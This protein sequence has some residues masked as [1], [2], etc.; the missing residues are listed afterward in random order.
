MGVLGAQGLACQI[1]PE[2]FIYILS[3]TRADTRHAA[4]GDAARSH[5]QTRA[6]SDP[7]SRWWLERGRWSSGGC[8]AETNAAN[9]PTRVWLHLSE[10][11]LEWT[12]VVITRVIT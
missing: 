8:R 6:P 10:S 7:P 3:V 1:S 12:S 9:G 2:H 4:H 11:P 5:L